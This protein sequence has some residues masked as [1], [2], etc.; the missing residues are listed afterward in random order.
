M[1]DCEQEE[2][3]ILLELARRRDTDPLGDPAVKSCVYV[4]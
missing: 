3:Q 2:G 1:L 4:V